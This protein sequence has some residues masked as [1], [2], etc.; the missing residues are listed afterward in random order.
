ML[1]VGSVNFF[2]KFT[3]ILGGCRDSKRSRQIYDKVELFNHNLAKY[4]ILFACGI[5]ASLFTLI[6]PIPI[7]YLIFGFPKPN[8]WIMPLPAKYETN[9]NAI[10]EN[11]SKNSNFSRD[12]IEHISRSFVDIH[13]IAGFYASLSFQLFN[14]Y[15]YLTLFIVVN[16]LH[17]GF[18]SYLD[19]MV[20]D[21]I[22][23]WTE[24]N[25]HLNAIDKCTNIT[26]R[27]THTK[28]T[29]SILID[30]IKMHIEII[31]FWFPT[32]MWTV[33]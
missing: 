31:R 9:T 7:C 18:C 27:G 29:R 24:L 32:F 5:T 4:F 6:I 30:S 19:A 11:P 8:D 28:R 3:L 2:S 13:T 25:Q 14:V 20:E 21:H 23:F 33:P 16:L 17:V 1:L 12:I 10:Y 15:C 22:S 26:T